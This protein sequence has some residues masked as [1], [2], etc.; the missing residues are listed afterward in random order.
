MASKNSREAKSI[1]NAFKLLGVDIGND[2]S[3]GNVLKSNH[4]YSTSDNFAESEK[5]RLARIRNELEMARERTELE[6]ESVLYYISVRGKGFT[7]KECSYCEQPF[8]SSYLAVSYCS[9]VCRFKSLAEHGIAWNV[10]GKTDLE[11]WNGRIPKTLGPQ[12]FVAAMMAVENLPEEE[13]ENE[14]PVVDVEIDE[15]EE[16]FE[17][18]LQEIL[19]EESD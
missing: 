3:V 1:A 9:N 16:D 15:D 11:R 6:A 7:A 14:E 18:M 2:T 13:A 17:V 4:S 19:A 8:A 10:Y 5:D 12:A